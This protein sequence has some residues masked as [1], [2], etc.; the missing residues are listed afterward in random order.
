[1][2]AVIEIVIVDK[3]SSFILCTRKIKYLN[4]YAHVFK[5]CILV[6]FERT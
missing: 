5:I 1:M 6:L 2:H 3:H 4:A